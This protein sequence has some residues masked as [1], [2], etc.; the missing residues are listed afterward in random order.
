MTFTPPDIYAHSLIVAIMVVVFGAGFHWLWRLSN[1]I[2]TASLQRLALSMAI[3]EYVHEVHDEPSLDS[4]QL[5][6]RL[7]DLRDQV[8]HKDHVNAVFRGED[9]KSLYHPDIQAIWPRSIAGA[10]R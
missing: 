1:A 10:S 8:E 5:M 7:F 4:Y 9:P 3:I 2:D 6:A